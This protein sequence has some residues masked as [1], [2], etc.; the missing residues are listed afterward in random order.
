MPLIIVSSKPPLRREPSNN[1]HA[2]ITCS[3]KEHG[4]I[5]ILSAMYECT[6][7]HKIEIRFDRLSYVKFPC[8]LADLLSSDA[9]TTAPSI[10]ITLHLLRDLQIDVE[11]LADASIEAD[12]LALV[13]VA[14]TVIWWYT[15]LD[16]RLCKSK[17]LLA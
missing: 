6:W 5:E 2:F 4:G 7:E 16:T 11:K 1:V 13:Q 12:A 3:T 10:R 8:C 17:D 14:F 9:H 15:L